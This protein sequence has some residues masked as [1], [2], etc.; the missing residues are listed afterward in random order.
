MA[1]F[2]DMAEHIDSQGESFIETFAVMR[3]TREVREF[4]VGRAAGPEIKFH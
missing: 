2:F 3:D 4:G 1:L